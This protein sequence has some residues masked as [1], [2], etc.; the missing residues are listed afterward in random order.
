MLANIG[1]HV[2]ENNL[3]MYVINGLSHKYDVIAI[4]IHHKSPFLNFT[5]M[6]FIL[7]LEVTKATK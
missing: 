7:T 5:K 4:T 3:V 2:P 6:Q 1:S